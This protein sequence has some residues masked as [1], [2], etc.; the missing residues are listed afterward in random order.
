VNLSAGVVVVRREGEAWRYLLLRAY[1]NWDFP[2]GEAEPGEDPL[3]TAKREVREETGISDLSFRWGHGFRE[4]PPYKGGRK[5]ARYY[6]AETQTQEVVFSVNPELGRPE[7]VE[8][9]WC[10]CDELARLAPERLL[11]VVE[12]AVGVVAGGG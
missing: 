10:G 2:K 8:H 1:K 4:T 11:G 3:E 6:V 12:W 5:I 9:R 7:H